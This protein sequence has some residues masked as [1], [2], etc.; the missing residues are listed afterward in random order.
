M[1]KL[2]TVSEAA[3]LVGMTSETLRHYDRIGLVKP[4]QRDTWTGYRYYTKQE[5]VRLNTIQALRYMDLSLR[6]IKE[7]LAMDDLEQIVSFLQQAEQQAD[8]KIAKLQY[9]KAKMALARA[10][11]EKKRQGQPREQ[12]VF[13]QTIPERVILLSDTMEYPTL[14][15][16]WLYHEHFYQ[17]LDTD[18]RGAY[19]FEDLAGIYTAG[20]VSRLFAVCRQ[21]PDRDGLTILPA[22]MYLCANCTQ[23]T[24]ESVWRQ[25]IEAVR[26]ETGLEPSF[27]IQL[28]VVSGILQ[29]HYQIQVP[30]LAKH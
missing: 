11:Y 9:A 3:Q 29:W 28:V 14:D 5:I 1:D 24:R 23:E 26:E 12:E 4:G 18:R 7:L 19:T 27:T 30:L 8:E 25:L 2:Y 16:L 22:G 6:E 20:D 10:D 13:R 15:K 17:Q 21:Y